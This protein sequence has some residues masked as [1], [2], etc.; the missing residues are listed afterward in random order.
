MEDR[1]VGIK[2]VVPLLLLAHGLGV[3]AGFTVFCFMFHTQCADLLQVKTSK[4]DIT[5]SSIRNAYETRKVKDRGAYQRKTLSEQM[6]L[7]GS[8]QRLVHAHEEALSQIRMLTSNLDGLA[9]K[10][11][12]KDNESS[13]LS[14]LLERSEMAVANT[15]RW[16]SKEQEMLKRQLSLT[17]TMLQQRENEVV[18][19]NAVPSS[20]DDAFRGGVATRSDINEDELIKLQAAIRRRNLAQIKQAFG[21]APYK[22][23][24][25]LACNHSQLA[26]RIVELEIENLDE[27]AHSV[28]TFLSL[29]DAGLYQGTSM[30][31]YSDGTRVG[32]GNPKSSTN[33]HVQTQLVRRYGELAYGSYPLL[34]KELSVTK[35]CVGFSFGFVGRGPDFVIQL[36]AASSALTSC[37]GRIIR[38]QEE[39]TAISKDDRVTIINT[40]IL[41]LQRE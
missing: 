12:V 36:A 17:K 34:F 32:G 1:G 19:L 7:L 6:A 5:I 4:H 23:Q 26:P 35:P 25:T 37:F 31:G 22:V 20:H 40:R 41:S 21:E 29:I 38:G 16:A 2:R 11:K 27:M 10:A 18:L 8:H 24:F 14:S 33:K 15:K 9:E 30:N 39:L 28:F 3:L 13:R